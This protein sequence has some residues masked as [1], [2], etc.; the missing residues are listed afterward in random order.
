MTG[1]S[2]RNR[3]AVSRRAFVLSSITALAGI[4]GA[5]ATEPIRIGLTL[6]LTGRYSKLGEM[7]QRAYLLWE[8]QI[9]EAGG[10]L[11]RPVKVLIEDDGSGPAKAAELYQRL[12]AEDRVDLLFGPYSS[13]ITSA[14]A[15][16]ADEA[17]FPLLA[18]GASSDRIWQQGYRY[19]FG[20]YTPASRYALGVLNLALL[21]D[22]ETVAIVHADDAFSVSAGEGAWKW[23]PR[24][25]LN[26]V[27]FEEFEKG[28]RNLAD[29]AERVKFA[30]PGLL[31]MAGHFNESIDMRRALI[32]V[33]WYPKAYFATI[34]PVL[35]RYRD[36]LKEAA[37]LSFASSLWEPELRFPNSREF[38]ASFRGMFHLEPTYHA[39][40]AYAAGQILEA[41]VTN[42]GSLDRGSIRDALEGLQTHTV[43]GR[44]L[45]D[46]T[47][48]QVKHFPLTIQWQKGRK[49]IV[50]PEEVQTAQPIFE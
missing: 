20:V 40:T 16:V 46:A 1:R 4:R 12:I 37:D 24:L 14:V 45:V 7:Q 41:A 8:R 3:I 34:G 36:I 39:A 9:N 35:A 27:M 13:G 18:A 29:L 50:W 22:L 11:G 21:N 31:I 19:I 28:T 47:G 17:G 48:I 26:V 10:L 49:E 38:A 42:V 15:P 6:S 44:Y 2:K 23:A 5:H 32:E 43:V 33:D 30:A 25:G